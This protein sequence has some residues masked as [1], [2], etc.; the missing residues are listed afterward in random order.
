MIGPSPGGGGPPPLRAQPNRRLL[1]G[2][3]VRGVL[4]RSLLSKERVIWG[5]SPLPLAGQKPAFLEG[6]GSKMGGGSRPAHSP[7]TVEI[8]QRPTKTSKSDPPGL[9]STSQ[10]TFFFIWL[11]LVRLSS[12]DDFSS[13]SRPNPAFLEGGGHDFSAFLEGERVWRGGHNGQI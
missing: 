9:S 12:F 7:C 5:G 11:V 1:R 2:L 6:G 8:A 4:R 13:L 10:C 3:R